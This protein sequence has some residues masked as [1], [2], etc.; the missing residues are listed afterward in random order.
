[1]Y[2]CT[3]GLLFEICNI[4]GE[5][6]Q[7][8]DG[9]QGIGDATMDQ[10]PPHRHA[11]ENEPF[12]CAAVQEE[13]IPVPIPVPVPVGFV[14]EYQSET[15]TCVCNVLDLSLIISNSAVSLHDV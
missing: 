15:E 4:P 2:V 14:W 10:V 12:S 13:T 5:T 9:N 7:S 11:D 8:T 1:M 3:H 6:L